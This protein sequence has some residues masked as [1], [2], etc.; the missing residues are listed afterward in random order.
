MKHFKSLSEYPKWRYEIKECLTELKQYIT[1]KNVKKKVN[2]YKKMC[3]GL[4]V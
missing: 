1:V 4:F 2:N 3:C